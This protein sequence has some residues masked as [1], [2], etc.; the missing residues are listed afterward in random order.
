MVI[1]V[2]AT[3]NNVAWT[4]TKLILTLIYQWT[5]LYHLKYPSV[6]SRGCAIHVF[7]VIPLFYVVLFELSFADFQACRSLS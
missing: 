1:R 3:A 5:P 7:L 6:A 4:S 2:W